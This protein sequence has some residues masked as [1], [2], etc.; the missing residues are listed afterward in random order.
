MT[1]AKEVTFEDQ[2]KRLEDI[3]G[4]MESG[5]LTLDE[6]LKLYEEGVKLSQVALRFGADDFGGI[7]ME[8]NVVTAT[9][10]PYAG[11]TPEE[12]VRLIRD[13]GK[14]P[15]QRNTRYEVIRIFDECLT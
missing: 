5:D 2:L 14:I 12:A 10:V 4:R 8:E 7:L 3:V 9:G 6:S 15:A 13:T 11:M 1:Q